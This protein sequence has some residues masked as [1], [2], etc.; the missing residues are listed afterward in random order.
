MKLLGKGRDM[1]YSRKE[2]VFIAKKML[3][4]MIYNSA[5]VEGCNVTFPQTQAI[6]DG[7]VVNHVKMDDIQTVIN[8]RDAWRFVLGHLDDEIN[9]DFICKVNEHISRNESLD[10]GVLR[11]GNV[12]VSGTAYH[13]PIPEKQDVIQMLDELRMMDDPIEYACEYFCWATRAQLFWDGN[14]RTSTLVANAILIKNGV[15]VFTIDAQ[16]VD[17]FNEKLLHLYD[18]NDSKKL[19]EYIK[20]QIQNMSSK[21][22]FKKNGR[23]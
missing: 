14:K 2:N 17:E 8:L 6:L 20:V 22:S 13:P 18:T 7:M 3:S 9:L 12:G 15:G 23:S 1:M 4:E 16:T 11:Y 19:K 21:F 5:Y 10:W